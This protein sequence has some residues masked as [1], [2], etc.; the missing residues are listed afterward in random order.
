MVAALL[1]ET[2]QLYPGIK[3]VI[4]VA[5]NDIGL[6]REI[7]RQLEGAKLVPGGQQRQRGRVPYPGSGG[8]LQG[9]G[10]PVIIA[11]GQGASAG[12]AAYAGRG[13]AFVLGCQGDGKKR[14]ASLDEAL[15]GLPG[16]LL[17]GA[18]GGQIKDTLAMPL[19]QR[20]DGGKQRGY[21]LADAGRRFDHHTGAI[22]DAAVYGGGHG[23]LPGPEPIKGEGQRRQ[24]PIAALHADLAGGQ[25]GNKPL[26]KLKERA[27]DIRAL[28][29][30][31]QRAGFAGMKLDIDE[32]EQDA[33]HIMGQAP[34]GSIAHHLGPIVRIGSEPLQGGG[35]GLQLLQAYGRALIDKPV[36][37]AGNIQSQMGRIQGI[38]KGHLGLIAGR[39]HLLLI[40][41]VQ[42]GA[43]L[44]AAAAGGHE[45]QVAL[46]QGGFYKLPN[47]ERVMRL[48]LHRPYYKPGLLQMQ[49]YVY[50]TAPE[51]QGE[52]RG[53]AAQNPLRSW[54]NCDKISMD[55][56]DGGEYR[57]KRGAALWV[58][59]VMIAALAGGCSAA[60][61]NTLMGNRVNLSYAGA[62]K[63]GSHQYTSAVGELT[64]RQD[65]PIE[66][67][68]RPF[69]QIKGRGGIFTFDDGRVLSGSL[70]AS[71]ALQEVTVAVNTEVKQSDYPKME[72]ALLVYQAE[73]SILRQRNT[74][75]VIAVI[76]LAALAAA[77]IFATAP[78][79]GWLGK[80]GWLPQEKRKPMVQ[81]AR[82]A[83][84]VLAAVALIIILIAV[85]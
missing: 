35:G 69:A 85:F 37:P 41:L 77:A 50:N 32:P 15:H 6:Q 2:A 65:A 34:H 19:P 9:G 24:R 73:S 48:I 44:Q 8:F 29:G 22:T 52:S 76:V 7:Q 38:A 43:L 51:G 45:H 33:L 25:P 61:Q 10:K 5:D 30:A 80:R 66:L 1:E 62:Q 82:L 59:L 27:D 57:M 71:G 60:R 16:H 18:P 11:G 46:G 72:A 70:D 67:D 23:A 28:I 26:A 4:K 63:D 49:T 47:R 54:K 21:G 55:F 64:W 81:I 31:L 53:R 83:G 78:L 84:I 74:A 20:L 58:A 75:T 36:D 42:P 68:G 40:L 79:A 3:G 13:A 39:L 17:E 14:R 56:T 12:M